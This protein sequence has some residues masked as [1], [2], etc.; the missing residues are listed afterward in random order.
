ML[1]GQLQQLGQV[2]VGDV[3][4]RIELAD[5]GVEIFLGEINAA[6]CRGDRRG[7]LPAPMQV[8]RVAAPSEAGVEQHGCGEDGSHIDRHRRQQILVTQC[9]HIAAADHRRQRG[10]AAGGMDAAQVMHGADR[11][12]HRQRAGPGLVRGQ[13]L[14]AHADEGRHQMP[15]HYRPRL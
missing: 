14:T 13:F 8:H 12:A 6:L 1:L 11:Q 5:G 15:G 9:M 3:H 7:V 10:R 4:E 2:V